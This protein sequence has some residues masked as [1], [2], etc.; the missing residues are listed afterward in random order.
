MTCTFIPCLL[1]LPEWN[2]RSAVMRSIG[3]SVPSRRGYAFTGAVRTPSARSGGESGQELDRLGDIAGGRRDA[4]SKPGR[5]LGIR[6]VPPADGRGCAGPGG[7]Y[8]AT[9]PRQV[10][11]NVPSGRASARLG[12]RVR[13]PGLTG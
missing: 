2:G 4:D 7:R 8:A 6:V 13:P 11:G 10:R 1:C 12:F 9:A 5:E 3:R